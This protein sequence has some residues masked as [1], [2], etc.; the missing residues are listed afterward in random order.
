VCLHN[1]NV[2]YFW[3]LLYC[4]WLKL[5]GRKNFA[6]VLTPHGGFNPEWSIFSLWTRVKKEIYQ[7][8]VGSIL[9]NLV[10][11]A[12]RAVS[13][14][15]RKEIIKMGVARNKVITIS[16]G[17][18]DEA[19]Q[20]ID[21]QASLEIKKTV[22]HLGRYIIQV[23]R[24]YPIKNY[25]TSI[26]ALV[27][28]P[29]DLKYVIVGP[30]QEDEKNKYYK[31]GLDDLISNLH[32]QDRVKFLGVVKGID[33]FYLIKHAQMMVHMAIWESFCNVVHEGLSQG[34]ICLVAN[35]TALPLLIKDGINGY[36]IETHNFDAL[37][38]KINYVLENKNSKYFQDM[39]NRNKKVGRETRWSNVA[40]KMRQLYLSLLNHD[41]KY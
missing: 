25:E 39:S 11:D 16:N 30:I 38:E 13:E 29:V 31:K 32:L 6:L 14:W 36:C 4:L 27:K 23:G 17:I 20:D 18:E 34:L 26:K 19:Y 41:Q 37:A 28:M 9:I 8:T 1:F 35:N 12:V 10:V 33:K 5:T 15:E 21:K 3:I 40:K 7:Y 24:V 2:F 22:K